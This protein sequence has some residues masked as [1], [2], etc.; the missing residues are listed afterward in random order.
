MLGQDLNFLDGG[1]RMTMRTFAH[2]GLALCL[3]LG[4]RALAG[5]ASD[6]P[7]NPTLAACQSYATAQYQKTRGAQFGSID[8]L[9]EGL[10]NAKSDTKAGAQSVTSVLSGGA[11]W[12]GKTGE[13]KE[14]RFACL[15]DG[16]TPIFFLTLGETRRSPADACWDGFEAAAWDQLGKCLGDALKREEAALEKRLT[17]ATDDGKQSMDRA[18]VEKTLKESNVQWAKYRDAECD[19][20]LAAVMGRNHPDVGE[21][22]CRLQKTSQRI[23]DLR[24]DEDR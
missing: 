20:R 21:L 11:V 17:Q 12:K 18:S 16:A 10:D 4:S 19:R 6:A 3:L 15:L 7:D 22:T 1:D 5:A 8:L 13:P 9:D 24:F 23:E 14:T 2:A